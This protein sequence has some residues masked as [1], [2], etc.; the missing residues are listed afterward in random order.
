MS[1]LYPMSI[2]P[3]IHVLPL[4][5]AQEIPPW[6]CT[7]HAAVKCMKLYVLSLPLVLTFSFINSSSRETISYSFTNQKHSFH[8]S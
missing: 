2:S 4:D 1:V 5:T 6:T 8:Y 7:T 3:C